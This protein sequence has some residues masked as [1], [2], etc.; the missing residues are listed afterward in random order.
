MS[1]TTIRIE[2][3]TS[4][5]VT[6]TDG[7]Y[8]V[9][10]DGVLD[11]LMETVNTHLVA[12]YNAKRMTSTEMVR[13]YIGIVP[14]AIQQSFTFVLQKQGTEKQT[15]NLI[16]DGELKQAQ[17]H[18][19]EQ[20][21]DNLIIDGELKQEQIYAA[22]RKL[23]EDMEKWLITKSMMENQK[24]SSDIELSIKPAMA[25]AELGQKELLLESAEAD[26]SFNTSKK[27]IMEHTRKDNVRMKATEQYAE[28]LKYSSAAGAI[29]GEHHFKNMVGL[30]QSIN[31]GVSN[32]NIEYD[33]IYLNDRMKDKNGNVLYWINAT[34]TGIPTTAFTEWPAYYEKDIGQVIANG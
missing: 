25:N 30:V 20:Q 33:M 14:T 13:A 11:K 10:G 2:D 19:T 31:D 23:E 3:L 1:N 5:V 28:Y 29:P 26:I 6:S 16:I 17:I 22:E 7:K 8:A 24:A 12:H 21:T 15:D 18:T 4:N 27:I 34:K 9:T 32:P